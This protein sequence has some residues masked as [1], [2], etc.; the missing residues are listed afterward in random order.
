M[1]NVKKVNKILL[2][3]KKTFIIII[4]NYYFNT[5]DIFLTVLVVFCI[6]F[7]ILTIATIL[8]KFLLFI[9]GNNRHQNFAQTHRLK[10]ISEILNQNQASRVIN[11]SASLNSNQTS[12]DLMQSQNKFDSI[13][14][15]PSYNALSL[16]K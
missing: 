12:L 1:K 6:A 9:S 13:Y 3:L 11:N 7:A 16:S 5:K 4:Y 10:T 8:T 14:S 2:Y 15:L